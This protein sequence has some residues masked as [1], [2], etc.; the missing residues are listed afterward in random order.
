M[1]LQL[2]NRSPDLK[3][4][5]DDGFCVEIISGYLVVHEVPYVT[6]SKEVKLGKLISSLSLANDQ[7]VRPSDHQAMFSGE[8]PC[9]R[10]GQPLT[11]IINSSSTQKLCPQLVINHN[12]SSKPRRGYYE[13]YYEK[14]FTYAA[15][16]SSQAEALDPNVTARTFR[17]VENSDSESPFHYVDTASSRAG[18]VSLSRKLKLRSVAI[19]GLGG[20]GSYILDAI[21]KT[22]VGEIQLFDGDKFLQHNA[23]R[24]PG[25]AAAAQLQEQW[26]KV[27]YFRE[28]YSRMHKRIIAHPVFID[29]S[30]V[31]LLAEMDFVFLCLD[32][33]D[34][35]LAII[36]CLEAAGVSFIDVGMG[37]EIANDS[38]IGVIRVTTSTAS[39]RDHVQSK[40]RIPLVGNGEANMYAQNIQ[41]SELNMLNA[42]LAVI[43]WK[44]LMGFY[45][46]LEEE[47]F[48]LFSIDGNHL[49]NEDS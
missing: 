44:K 32:A 17:V 4:L 29:P 1:S 40:Q 2:I 25:A 23:F 24:A 9:D 5:R 6:P 34:A 30:N 19:V 48:S 45:G 8:V 35:K 46:D 41:I 16:L 13:D 22:E 10:H 49:L 15:I 42:A 26:A 11:K 18:I 33:S 43:K 3:R 7:T 20:T 47:Y 21:S 27:E 31:D 36:E 39:K 37:V 28:I 12:F 14:M 38:L